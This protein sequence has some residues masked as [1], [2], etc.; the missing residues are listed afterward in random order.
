MIGGTSD[1]ASW[2]ASG[3]M[4]LTGPADGAPLCEPA[5]L[6]SAML[7][8]AHDV[9]EQTA[10]VGRRV[11]IDGP[12]ML[13]ERAAIAGLHRN[14]ATSV[15]GAA[16]FVRAADGWIVLN[17]PR[18]SDVE[19][20]PALVRADIDPGDWEAVRAA[21]A[22]QTSDDIIEQAGW[23][24][25]AV[26]APRGDG[27]PVAP[28]R[29]LSLGGPRT[30]TARP[31]VVDLSSLWAGPLAASLLGEAG[32][33]VIKVE[34]RGRSDGARHGP[35]A[36]FDLLNHNKECVTVDF[37]DR[38]DRRFLRR[39]L[40]SADLVI[41]ASR[42]RVMDQLAIDPAQFALSGVSWLSL[43]AH[44]RTGD[45]AMRVGFGDDAA[46]AGGL[47]VDG[48]TPCFVADA[49]ADPI[50]GVAGAA[51][52]AELLAKDRSAVVEVPLRRAAAWA[53]RAPLEGAVIAAGDEWAV[54]ADGEQIPVAAPRHRPIPRPAPPIGAHDATIRAEL[55]EH[56]D[57]LLRRGRE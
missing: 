45:D 46:V 32:A 14:G 6:V 27:Q 42:P 3:A 21:L 38:E 37:N 8:A 53:R 26:A 47:W 50:A 51:L 39:L 11:D 16:R 13:G 1:L 2:A 19:A 41:E 34:G 30:P 10:A 52:G 54:V 35:A 55:A 25:L 7:A 23:L 4:A 28:G 12:A 57:R 17:L 15:G 43:T 48:E 20:L 9:A 40:I 22:T 49:V 24:G 29:E 44:G 18:P 56:G 31:L 5:G 36:F 33:R